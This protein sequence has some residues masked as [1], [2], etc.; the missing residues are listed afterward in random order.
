MS[1]SDI[2]EGHHDP[3]SEYSRLCKEIISSVPNR[4][5][6]DLDD[7]IDSLDEGM[8]NVVGSSEDA[9]AWTIEFQDRWV[10]LPSLLSFPFLSL[11]ASS[12]RPFLQTLLL[13]AAD[14]VE[15]D[16]SEDPLIQRALAC[17][18]YRLL[19]YIT[20]DWVNIAPDLLGKLY[21]VVRDLPKGRSIGD[22]H[23]N[24]NAGRSASEPIQ[25]DVPVH[26]L[27]NGFGW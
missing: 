5:V 4:I 7:D 3:Q 16:P 22:Y 1:S 25:I 11:I 24:P 20:A 8:T 26:P 10:S 23:P 14:H 9:Y 6:D 19:D 18:C 21:H 27:L 13:Q 2:D 15:E 17:A 12:L